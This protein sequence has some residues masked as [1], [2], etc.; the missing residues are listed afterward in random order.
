MV[1]FVI[2]GVQKFPKIGVNFSDGEAM[3]YFGKES[4]CQYIIDMKKMQSCKIYQ[5]FDI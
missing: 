5:H 3:A 1:T 4:T 2:F